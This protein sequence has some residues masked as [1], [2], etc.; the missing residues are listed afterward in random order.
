MQKYS[1]ILG[2]T[3]GQTKKSVVMSAYSEGIS[4]LVLCNNST[5][6]HT[7]A[8]ASVGNFVGPLLFNA[9]ENPTYHPGLRATLGFFVAFAIV[10]GQVS[11][12]QTR[13]YLLTT[14]VS[15][16]QVLNLMSLNKA[17]RARRVRNGKPA[18]PKDLS[19]ESKYVDTES[20]HGQQGGPRIGTH[21]TCFVMAPS[22]V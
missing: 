9:S 2:N 22:W 8:G 16:L 4:T 7:D 19:M 10:I 13:N 20:D 17:N 6:Y 5:I 1:I 15:S 11:A 14:S 21:G 3:A 12:V 18:D